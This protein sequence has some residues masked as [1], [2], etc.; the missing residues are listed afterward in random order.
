MNKKILV[1]V[2]IVVC[3]SSLVP[4]SYVINF[5]HLDISSKPEIW[6]AFGDFI[7]GILNPFLSFAAFISVLITVFMQQAQL[8]QNEKQL[9]MTRDELALSTDELKRSADAQNVQIDTAK[10]QNFESTFFNLLNRFESQIAHLIRVYIEEDVLNDSN[11]PSKFELD[12]DTRYCG[13]EH[14][15]YELYKYQEYYSSE[16]YGGDNPKR[17]DSKE[18]YYGITQHG[19]HGIVLDS[20][21]MHFKF[22]IDFIEESDI[23]DKRKYYRILFSELT[24]GE[25]IFV[26]YQVLYGQNLVNLKPKVEEYSLFEYIGYR[27]L[28]D[29]ALDLSKYEMTAY[30]NNDAIKTNMAYYFKEKTNKQIN[31]D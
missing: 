19:N 8:K 25:L 13:F 26:F 6:G 16:E 1:V 12:R 7:G 20:Y 22:L 30:G 2:I 23:S 10:L 17:C 15:R 28:I 11:V 4:I 21:F 27:G 31:A 29:N 3:L 24:N 14:L 9:E 18:A 5:G